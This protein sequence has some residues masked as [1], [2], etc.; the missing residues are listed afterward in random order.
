MGISLGSSGVLAVEGG[1]DV[2]GLPSRKELEV[3]FRVGCDPFVRGVALCLAQDLRP[4][5]FEVCSCRLWQVL[6]EL[7]NVCPICVEFS[8]MISFVLGCR[9][10]VSGDA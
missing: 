3:S 7:T 6:Y 10:W 5:L 1:D 8:R 4:L 2:S 9:Y